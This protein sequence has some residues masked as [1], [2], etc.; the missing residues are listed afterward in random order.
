[1]ALGVARM[2]SR[3]TMLISWSRIAA[4]AVSLLGAAV[5]HAADAPPVLDVTA[6]CEG[7]AAS[8]LA[9]GRDRDP[10]LEDERSAKDALGANWSTWPAADKTHCVGNVQSGGPASYVELLSC[11][12]VMKD[13]RDIRA[14]ARDT[15]QPVKPP[16]LR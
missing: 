2:S 11:L 1:M 4:V 8:G 13:A 7:A 12:E 6:S 10:C 15:P 16:K 14:E 9:G 5:A 3:N